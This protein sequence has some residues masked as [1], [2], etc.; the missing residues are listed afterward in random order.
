MAARAEGEGGR[1]AGFIACATVKGIVGILQDDTTGAIERRSL[2]SDDRVI[3][4]VLTGVT[5]RR[6]HHPIL[7]N[8]L[9]LSA[10][11]MRLVRLLL[12]SESILPRVHSSIQLL[13][14]P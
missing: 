11:V 10:E 12:D 6:F 2:A 13:Y 9:I 5:N 3:Q 14:T 4:P 1:G 8:R 7:Y